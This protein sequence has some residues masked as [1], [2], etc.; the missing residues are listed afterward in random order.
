MCTCHDNYLLTRYCVLIE[1]KF[2]WLEAKI[3]YELGIRT[4]KIR[5]LYP[6]ILPQN[7]ADNININTDNSLTQSPSIQ[8]TLL[9]LFTVIAA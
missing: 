8:L 9:Y 5:R 1:M 3:S 4:S 6:V 2:I 7:T